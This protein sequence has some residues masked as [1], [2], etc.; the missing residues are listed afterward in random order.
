VVDAQDLH[1]SRN[2]I[3]TM[4]EQILAIR[5]I[6]AD[7]RTWVAAFIQEHWG[8]D[9]M[10]IR[11]H[12][13]RISILP[14][15]VAERAGKV[16]GFI[17]YRIED[18][19][20]EITSL[21]SL[22]EGQGIGSALIESVRDTAKAAG[23]TRLWLITTNDNTDGLRFYQKRGFALVA[24]HR[25]A[26]DVSRRLKPQI[27]LIGMHGIPLRDEIELEQLI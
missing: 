16:V 9:L 14:G 18:R 21:D 27:P 7:D 5:P 25:N 13:V 1:M 8:D 11:G 20:C 3:A 4:S 6:N 12:L 17:S 19:A 10:A 26:M 22:V 2:D 24:V 15:F 23:C